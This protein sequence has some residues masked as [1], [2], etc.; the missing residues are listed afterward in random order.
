MTA[1]AA[2]LLSAVASCDK[3]K[4]DAPASSRDEGVPVRVVRARAGTLRETVR[5]I[6]TLRAAETVEIKSE[7]DGFIS[8]IHFEEGGKVE[9][10]QL[11]FSIDDEKLRH[12]LEAKEAALKAAQARLADAQRVFD[13]MQRLIHSDS[14][15]EDEIDEAETHL[16]AAVAEVD[17]MAAEVKLVQAQLDDTRLRA[18]FDGVVSERHVDVGDYVKADNHL[19]TIFRISRMEIAF[20]LPERFMGRVQPGQVA[21]VGVSAYPDREFEGEVY[22]VSPNVNETTRDFL[23]KA[24]MKNPGGLL[25]PGAFATTVVT[26]DVHQERLVIPEAALVATRE[27]YIIF[28]VEHETARRRAVRIGLREA[29]IVEIREGL[30][31]GEQVVRSGQMNLSDGARVRVAQDG[32][33]QTEPQSRP[34]A[35]SDE[36]S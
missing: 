33:G 36:R 29:G 8:E 16:R 25:K 6:G 21:I 15:A 18:S 14:A 22:F 28:V 5:G 24:K 2:V 10:G 17:G 26:L 7:M 23:V 34:Q 19:G 3:A 4:S 35:K 20:T 30:E 13:R 9:K 12:Q 11:L 32:D 31:L 1:M 27:G